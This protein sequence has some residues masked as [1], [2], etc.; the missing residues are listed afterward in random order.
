MIRSFV[1]TDH[2]AEVLAERKAGAISVVLPAREVAGTIAPI[3]ERILGLGSLVDQVLVVDAASADGS[4]EIAAR[5]GAEVRQEEELAPEYGPVLGK[6]DAMW[7]ALTAVRGDLVVY[8]DAD[9]AGFEAH[10]V[11]GLLGPLLCEDGV[12]F[13]KATYDRPFAAEGVELAAGGGRVSRLTARPLLKAFYP[14]LAP[15]SQ[16]LAGEVAATRELLDRLPFATG[17]GVETAML[18]D[19]LAVAGPGAIAQVDLGVRRNVHQPL[20][21]LEP[22]ADAVLAVVCERLCREGRLGAGDRPPAVVERP[23]W[24]SVRAPA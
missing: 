2:P 23:P 15:L 17:Y 22:M 14:E 4:A 1:H 9:T 21:A 24:A 6:G 7:R 10:F 5:E 3:V 13:A 16:P 8:V 18:L 11:T 20:P 12:R 19:V